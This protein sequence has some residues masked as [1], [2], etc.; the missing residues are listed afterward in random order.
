MATIPIAQDPCVRHYGG[1]ATAER[2]IHVNVRSNR[3]RVYRR[4][5]TSYNLVKE[6]TGLIDGPRTL[7]LARS[8]SWCWMHPIQVK[9]DGPTSS[10]GLLNFVVFCLGREIGFH[11]DHWERK[12]HLQRIP[13]SQSHGCI[14]V[15]HDDS[16]EF[17]DLVQLGDC[18]R[19]YDRKD[20]REPTFRSCLAHAYCSR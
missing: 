15:P 8:T 4:S 9:L 7:G 19:L 12:G 14:R 3:A 5:G 10:K 16:R 11:S 6:F 13:G 2:E 17:F 18:V 1:R 20:W